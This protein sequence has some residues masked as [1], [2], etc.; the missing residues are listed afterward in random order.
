M[1]EGKLGDRVAI[2]TGGG[3]GMGA[4][5]GQLLAD[6]G[7]KVLIGDIDAEKARSTALSIEASGGIST[8]IEVDVRSQPQVEEMVCAALGEHGRA[9]ILV[10]CAGVLRK[11]RID[12]ITT[13]E[14]ELVLD[15]NLKGTFLCSQAILPAMKEREYGRIVNISSSAGR[16][17]STLGGAHYTA[18]KA[19]VLGFTRALAKEVARF[20]I[21][22]NA[23]CPGL[24]DTD[25]A[26]ANCSPE[27]L[28]AYEESFPI[29]R[30]GTPEEVA[31]LVLFLASDATYI[32]GAAID[33][34]GGDLML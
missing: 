26:R 7:A 4:A 31:G 24:I 9:D 32:T 20:G 14:W 13:A 3:Q 23:V 1:R 22:S 5:I 10:N 17:V 11:T 2:V 30:L 12:E 19:G 8:W 15:V 34:N 6:E 27:R 29:P 16:S 33:I 21:T 25:M 28:R 18:A